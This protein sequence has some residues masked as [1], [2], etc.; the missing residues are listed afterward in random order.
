M[1]QLMP[2][3]AQISARALFGTSSPFSPPLAIELM[4]HVF[5]VR[6]DVPFLLL[7]EE[8]AYGDIRIYFKTLHQVQRYP[9][10]KRPN[11]RG[12]V[13]SVANS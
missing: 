13:G 11:A 4:V 9:G 6:T 3:V 2:G 10:L 12:C 1:A 5:L 7:S 8:V